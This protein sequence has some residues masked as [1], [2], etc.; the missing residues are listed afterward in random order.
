MHYDF[1]SKQET[2]TNDAKTFLEMRGLENLSSLPEQYNTSAFLTQSIE[3]IYSHFPRSTIKKLYKIY[4]SDML[5]F[6]YSIENL[7][8]ALSLK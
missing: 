4:F 6:D 8:L 2:S 1:I 5:L 7:L 3:D